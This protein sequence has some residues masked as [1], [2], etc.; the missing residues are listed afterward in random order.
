MI[1]QRCRRSVC[2]SVLIRFFTSARG[3]WE[4]AWV[5]R[6]ISSAPFVSLNPKDAN[7]IQKA[8]VC[9]SVS[10]AIRPRLL[11]LLVTGDRRE[12]LASEAALTVILARPSTPGSLEGPIGAGCRQLFGG[13]RLSY[14]GLEVLCERPIFRQGQQRIVYS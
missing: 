9:C 10:R 11:A 1:S 12:D 7:P 14:P 4:A 8:Q 5:I 2:G 13:R 3:R 6:A